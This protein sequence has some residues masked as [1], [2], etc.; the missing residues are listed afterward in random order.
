MDSVISIEYAICRNC[1]VEWNCSTIIVFLAVKTFNEFSIFCY[2]YKFTNVTDTPLWYLR[3]AKYKSTTHFE[4]KV[5][6]I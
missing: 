1:I 4:G 3:F 6:A 5:K 2:I